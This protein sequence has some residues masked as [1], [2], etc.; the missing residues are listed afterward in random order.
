MTLTQRLRPTFG[1]KGQVARAHRRGKPRQPSPHRHMPRL[2]FL[3][4]RLAP[5]TLMVTSPN[6]SGAGTL[7]AA[8]LNSVNR[9]G[10]GTG[11][12][13]IRFSAATMDGQTIRLSTFVNVAGPSAFLIGTS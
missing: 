10:G 8:I 13:T 3:E 9:T 5:A 4:D 2:E 11:S 1:T 12:D 6:D 7:R